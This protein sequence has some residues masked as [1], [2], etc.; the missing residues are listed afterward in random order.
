M[1]RPRNR[2]THHVVFAELNELGTTAHVRLESQHL[3]I[4][5]ARFRAFALLSAIAVTLVAATDSGAAPAPPGPG[6]GRYD[7]V[8]PGASSGIVLP[9]AAAAEAA[10][11]AGSIAGAFSVSQG[12]SAVYAMSLT[13]PPGRAGMTPSLSIAYDSSGGDGTLGVGV[14]LRGFSS[15]TRCPSTIAQDHHIRGIKYDALDALCLDGLRLVEVPATSDSVEEIHEYR[16]FPDTF[17]KVVGHYP[18]G[19]K[20]A[21]GAQYFEAF[22]KEGRIVTYGTNGT[23]LNEARTWAMK[24]VVASWSVSMERDRRGNTI[25]YSYNTIADPAD[26]H[27]LEQVP[28]HIDYTGTSDPLD[29][30]T[31]RVLFNYLTDA[32]GHT[33]FFDGMRFTRTQRLDTVRTLLTTDPTHS[34]RTYHFSYQASLASTRPLLQTIMECAADDPAQCKPPT[35]LGWS[36]TAASGFVESK[37]GYDVSH[38]SRFQWVMAD[39]NGD[40]IDDLIQSDAGPQGTNVNL[41]SVALGNGSSFDQ[42]TVWTAMAFPGHFE[43][44]SPWS[45]SPIDYDQDGKIDLLIDSP[46]LEWPTFMWLHSRADH[47]FELLD[48]H[49]PRPSW[50]WPGAHDGDD[51]GVSSIIHSGFRVSDIDGDGVGD[52][53][54]CVNTAVE[55]DGPWAIGAAHWT[56]RLWSPI[57]PGFATTPVTIAPIEGL[58]CWTLTQRVQFVD[59]DGDGKAEILAPVNGKTGQFIPTFIAH[60]YDGSGGFQSIDT[61]IPVQLFG[62][63]SFLDMN[64]DGLAEAILPVP[65]TMFVD[66]SQAGNPDANPLACDFC[67]DLGSIGG[68]YDQTFPN[69]VEPPAGPETLFA[70][71]FTAL[72]TQHRDDGAYTI[73]AGATLS[74]PLEYMRYADV[75]KSLDYDGDGMMDLLLPMRHQCGNPALADA[76]WVVLQSDHNG[77]G[78]FTIVPTYIPWYGWAGQA[79]VQVT[80]VNGDGRPDLVLPSWASGFVVYIN[81]STPDLVVSVTDGLNALDPGDTGFLPNVTISY[82]N[83]VDSSITQGQLASSAEAEDKTYLSRFEPSNDCDYPRAC[84]VGAQRVV[85]GYQLNNGANEARSFSV[86]Y[87]DGR[88]DRLGRGSLGFGERIVRD[89]DTLTGKLVGSIDLYD[90]ITYDGTYATY[91][92]AGQATRSWSWGFPETDEKPLEVQ[93]TSRESWMLTRPTSGGA[94]YFTLPWKTQVR[95]G[96]S[97]YSSNS[98]TFDTVIAAAAASPD[99]VV[100]NS[101]H[102]VSDFDEYGDVLSENDTVDDVDL[103]TT[104]TRTYQSDPSAWRVGELESESTC[105]SALGATQC[106]AS[107]MTYNS[108]GEVETLSTGDTSDLETQLT[109]TFGYDAFGNVATVRADDAFLHHRSSCLSYEQEG[110]FPYS[111][112]NAAGHITYSATEP[113]LGVRTAFVDANNLPTTWTHDAFGRITS[114]ARPDGTTTTHVL[115]RKRNDGGWWS[116]NVVAS[117]PGNG[118]TITEY[119]SLSRAAHTWTRGPDVPSCTTNQTCTNAAW[120]ESHVEYDRSGRVV[121]Q[122]EPWLNTDLAHQPSSKRTYDQVGRV[123][124]DETPWGYVTTHLYGKHTETSKDVDGLE[125]TYLDALGRVVAVEDKGG[126]LTQYTYGPFSASSE[127]IRAGNESTSF[128]HDAYG[129]VRREMDPDRGVTHVHYDGFNDRTSMDD[130]L[131]RVY[132]FTYDGLGR[133]TLLD[134]ALN[135][136]T[137]THEISTWVYDTA[138]NGRGKLTRST[139]PDD[140]T[141]TYEYDSM[142]RHSALLLAISGGETFKTG[143]TYDGFGRQN[144]RVYPQPSGVSSPLVVRSDYDSNGYL[145]ALSDNS[146]NIPYWQLGGVDAG[147]RLTKEKFGDSGGVV[148]MRSYDAHK[149]TLKTVFTNVALPSDPFAKPLQN[150]KYEFDDRLNLESREDTSQAMTEAFTYDPLDRLQCAYFKAGGGPGVCHTDVHYAPN[151]NITWKLGVGDYTYGND[152]SHPTVQGHAV[153]T[154]GGPGQSYFHDAVGNQ[155][156][157]PGMEIVYTSF[158]LPVSMDSGAAHLSFEYDADQ[159]RV[160]K[161]SATRET[162]S[163]GQVYERVAEINAPVEHRYFVEAGSA[164]VVVKKTSSAPD[165]VSYIFKDHLGSPDV[166]T[167]D[168]WKVVERRSYDAFGASRDASWTNLLQTPASTKVSSIGFTGHESDFEVDLVNMKGRTYDPKIGRFL[169]TDPVTSDPFFSQQWNPYSYVLNNP[170]KHVDPSGFQ[171]DGLDAIRAR[172]EEF[173]EFHPPMLEPDLPIQPAAKTKK[174]ASGAAPSAPVD[175]SQA[176]LMP[177]PSAPVD[178]SPV[179]PP[180]PVNSNAG[181]DGPWGTNTGQWSGYTTPDRDPVVRQQQR[182]EA[183]QSAVAGIK[184][185]GEMLEGAFERNPKLIFNG[186]K[187][188]VVATNLVTAETVQAIEVIAEVHSQLSAPSA[189]SPGRSGCFGVECTKSCFVAGTPIRTDDGVKSIEQLDLGERV[190]TLGDEVCSGVDWGELGYVRFESRDNA[191]LVIETLRPLAWITGFVRREGEHTYLVLPEI[192]FEGDVVVAKIGAPTPIESGVGCPILTKYSRLSSRVLTLQL[193]RP[194]APIGTTATHPFFSQD[195]GA[196]VHAGDLRVGEHVVTWSGSSVV[197]ELAYA[198]RVERVF[199]LEVG[200]AHTYLV[201]DRLAWVHNTCGFAPGTAQS[202]L[203]GMR[204]DG[205]HAIRHFGEEKLIPNTGSLQSRV[206]AFGRIAIPILEN[207]VHTAPWRIGGTQGRAFLGNVNGRPVA[208]IVATEGAFQGKV[209]GAIAPDPS[210]LAIMNSR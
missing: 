187:R 137:G 163:V 134:A 13:V 205:G 184:G 173:R 116:L 104:T 31:R 90:N 77:A 112:G 162:I 108:H 122:A 180:H 206:A 76:C 121:L 37:T 45:I 146:S 119:D 143:I 72:G 55:H 39:V 50:K 5:S 136:A 179:E 210:Q 28:K 11:A 125:E 164:T 147:G 25:T 181:D 190:R 93:V 103:A 9:L 101:F 30:G 160:R 131:G 51:E 58:P 83:L 158:D 203:D 189:G 186:A 4:P 66:S 69:G 79:Q 44:D 22:T 42:P 196:W 87:R 95:K 209:I 78:M 154:A 21:K 105:S 84:V 48:T 149:G 56:V 200:L 118:E 23:I 73:A 89:L 114:E 167:S 40:G 166:I 8:C 185:L 43:G 62:R 57:G 47:T 100:S 123:R 183:E 128:T 109:T 159:A 106:R 86:Q 142:G 113:R 70:K 52:L 6:Q 35:R 65:G 151:G 130:A 197:A 88:Y 115:A 97:S 46:Q 24:G 133:T 107:G 3:S 64:A 36:S 198:G 53:V 207:P 201:G 91:P 140:H 67:S 2:R 202:A 17:T 111:T 177:V 19:W 126:N 132:T 110:Y 38:D 54:Q 144:L 16:T 15:I 1:V 74:A 49:I 117:S 195:R 7:V 155:K 68:W 175:L 191:E 139:S 208:I 71:H 102:V 141:K 127:V 148:S 169:Q 18:S 156:I 176:A 178:A 32:P 174:A 99:F 145:I 96:E 29:P 33:V 129:R 81:R 27:T 124:T 194:S 120:F 193:A 188:Y 12:G 20:T 165:E 98:G 41:W 170:L 171:S 152:P 85:A 60:S 34:I 80:D 63:M 199:N 59:V 157:R 153:K 138:L 182:A 172:K 94:T 10:P 82:G 26:N 135:D 75:A 92:Y 150:L 168:S 14:S 161:L 61:K 204:N 192:E